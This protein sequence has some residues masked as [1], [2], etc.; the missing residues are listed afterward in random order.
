MTE[1]VIQFPVR[2]PDDAP[3]RVDRLATLAQ[4]VETQ[5]SGFDRCQDLPDLLALVEKCSP[6]LVELGALLARHDQDKLLSLM[7]SLNTRIGEARR[8]LDRPNGPP[9]AQS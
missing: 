9:G 1:N 6:A 8:R 7:A 4:H 5:L 2:E 3:D